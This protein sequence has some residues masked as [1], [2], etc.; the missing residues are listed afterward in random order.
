M[1]ETPRIPKHVEI[2]GDEEVFTITEIAILVGF[3]PRSVKNWVDRGVLCAYKFGAG[4]EDKTNDNSNASV[5][6]FGSDLKAFFQKSQMIP[7]RFRKLRGVLEK[8]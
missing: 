3:T 8:I 7:K 4:I 5:R 2:V 1:A 6:I